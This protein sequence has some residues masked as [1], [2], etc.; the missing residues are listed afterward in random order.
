MGSGLGGL[1]EDNKVA[2]RG[3]GSTCHGGQLIESYVKKNVE[4]TVRSWWIALQSMKELLYCI[5]I[6]TRNACF[7]AD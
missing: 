1:K 6:A 3:K 7:Q 5:M 4:D 2:L